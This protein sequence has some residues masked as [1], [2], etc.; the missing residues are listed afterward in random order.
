MN[1]WVTLQL[2]W[3]G[4]VAN[5]P[6]Q[7]KDVH[8]VFTSLLILAPLLP[9][10]LPHFP[11]QLVFLLPAFFFLLPLSAAGR[12][13]TAFFPSFFSALKV[14]HVESVSVTLGELVGGGCRF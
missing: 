1:H 14:V 7:Q 4:N 11:L 13:N 3:K 12:R 8:F 10:R 6:G 9:L 2:L 5:V